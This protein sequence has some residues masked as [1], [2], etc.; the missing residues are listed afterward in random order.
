MMDEE[1]RDAWLKELSEAD[2]IVYRSGEIRPIKD[3]PLPGD[4]IHR[5][6]HDAQHIKDVET[7]LRRDE[8]DKAGR[9]LWPRPRSGPH[10]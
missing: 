8:L 1:D 5:T 2:G 7:L 9:G 6:P 10:I 4:H 3:I